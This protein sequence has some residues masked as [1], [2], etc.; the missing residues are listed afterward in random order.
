ADQLEGPAAIAIQGL[1]ARLHA[2][3]GELRETEQAMGMQAAVAQNLGSDLGNLTN[4]YRNLG[5]EVDE[6]TGR[7]RTMTNAM[8]EQAQ[9][10]GQL[11]NLRSEIE[12]G[13]PERAQAAER[14]SARQAI[15][16]RRD[17]VLALTEEG[18]ERD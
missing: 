15:E 13:I 1:I 17:R 7:I 11:A 14:E 18:Q 6:T 5:I 4:F 8:D 10:Q 12:Q 2:E 9:R 16:D 3:Q